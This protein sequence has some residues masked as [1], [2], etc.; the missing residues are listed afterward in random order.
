MT[1]S[2]SIKIVLIIIVNIAADQISKVLVRKNFDLYEKLAL[3]G[4]IKGEGAKFLMYYVENEGAFLGMGSDLNPAIKII[5]LLIL[6]VLV[7]AYVTYY[8]F[9]TKSLDKWSVFA[10]SCIIGGGIANVFDRIVFGQVTDFF[11]ISLGGIF[12]TGIFNIADISVTTGLIIL[13]LGNF[14]GKKQN[15]EVSST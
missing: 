2:R 13:V 5:F 1:I 6:P 14:F 12:K 4:D 8:I 15:Q 3:L 9:K 11:Y 7:L 10:F